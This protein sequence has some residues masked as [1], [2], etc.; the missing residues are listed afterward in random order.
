MRNRDRARRV[1]R[2]K[3]DS[4]SLCMYKQ[5]RNAVQM[6]VRQA[7]QDY[8]IAIFNDIDNTN[9]VWNKLRHLGL[10]KAK[11]SSGVLVFNIDELNN[12][13]ASDE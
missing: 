11:N 4:V 10:I 5:L 7:K 8:Y 12:Y 13:F 9:A 1:W 3:R 6:K 2:R